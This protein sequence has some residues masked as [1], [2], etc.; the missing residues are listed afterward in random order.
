M[1]NPDTQLPLE[2]TLEPAEQA[3]VADLI[4]A[5]AGSQTPIYPLGGGLGLGYGVRPTRLGLGLSLAGLKRVVDHPARDLTITV[6]AGMTLGE[7]ATRLASERQRLPVDVPC[8]R[9]ATIGGALATNASGPRRCA[10]GTLRDYLLGFQAVDG[11]GKAFAGGGRVVKNAA[12]Y[13]MCKLIVGSLGT[14]AVTTQVTLMVRPIP[15]ASAMVA[16]EVAEF[17]AA[18]RILASVADRGVLPV[19]VE[20]LAGPAWANVPSLGAAASG[21]AARIVVGLEGPQTEVDWMVG[22]LTERWPALGSRNIAALV[23][24]RT[25]DLWQ[26]LTDFA[27]PGADGQGMLTAK[28]AVQPSAVA[29]LARE[30]VQLTG[31]LSLAAHAAS[32]T[33][34]VSLGGLAADEAVAMLAKKLRPAVCAAH[35]NLVVTAAP[36]GAG[37]SALDVWGPADAGV[38]LMQQIKQQFDPAG[39]LNPGRFIFPAPLGSQA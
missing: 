2:K 22:R 32:G 36:E 33:L 29:P 35:G 25:S 15:E 14:L 28:I 16:C 17:D 12:G 39:I 1:S 9:R 6:E 5:A 20:L 30:L 10:Y 8:P 18:E 37:L 23:G 34:R 31:Q 4:G 24:E 27:M 7:L 38:A 3:A 26:R 19:A 13:D 21:S 11:R